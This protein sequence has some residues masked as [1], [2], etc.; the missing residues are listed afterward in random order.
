MNAIK[1]LELKEIFQSMEIVN[2]IP[3]LGLGPGMGP[4]TDESICIYEYVMHLARS[5]CEY[6]IAAV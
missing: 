2:E 6:L 5:M 3:L 4:E 1:E